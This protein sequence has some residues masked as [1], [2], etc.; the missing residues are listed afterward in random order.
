MSNSFK[1]EVKVEGFLN[2]EIPKFSSY[3]KFDDPERGTRSTMSMLKRELEGATQEDMDNLKQELNSLLEGKSNF[4][5][6]FDFVKGSKSFKVTMIEND[7]TVIDDRTDKEEGFKRRPYRKLTMDSPKQYRLVDL[8]YDIPLE[9]GNTKAVL[10]RRN[11]GLTEIYV[12]A[13]LD[14]FNVLSHV[15][16]VILGNILFVEDNCKKILNPNLKL[17]KTLNHQRSVIESKEYMEWLEKDHNLEFLN[18]QLTVILGELKILLK[19]KKLHPSLRGSVV[20]NKILKE[21]DSTG[22]SDESK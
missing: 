5:P 13:G 2:Q 15:E 19:D 1:Y 20:A 14:L 8:V 12:L 3:V 21:C 7:I 11:E 18:N 4:T 9:T 16:N 22:S 17:T 10:V 6:T